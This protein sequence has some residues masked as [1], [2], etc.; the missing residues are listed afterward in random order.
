MPNSADA[1]EVSRADLS[2]TRLIRAEAF[3]APRYIRD[4]AHERGWPELEWRYQAALA[5]FAAGAR[6]WLEIVRHRGLDAAARVYRE[7]L[8]G[9]GPSA[10]AHVVNPVLRP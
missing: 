5:D 10:A 8:F 3:S 4:L 6:G 1:L 7:V 2:V 9:A